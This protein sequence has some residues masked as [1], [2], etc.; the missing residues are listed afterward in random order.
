MEIFQWVLHRDRFNFEL[1][2]QKYAML[3]SCKSRYKKKAQP[4]QAR[5]ED[6]DDDDGPAADPQLEGGMPLPIR[7]VQVSTFSDLLIC[8]SFF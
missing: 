6:D 3:L 2:Y 5:Y 7:Q 4:T 8:L 1:S